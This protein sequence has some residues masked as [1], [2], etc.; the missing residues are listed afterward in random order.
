LRSI[1]EK[2]LRKFALAVG[3]CIAGAALAGAPGAW[4]VPGDDATVIVEYLTVPGNSDLGELVDC[5]SSRRAVGGGV[6]APGSSWVLASGPLD[7]Q[8]APSEIEDGD[9]PRYWYVAVHNAGASQHTYPVYATCSASSDATVQ[10]QQFDVA[11]GTG[12]MPARDG[13]AAECPSE[14]RTIGGGLV[15]VTTPLS[16]ATSADASGPLDESGLTRNTEDGDVAM[17]WYSA[18][19]NVTSGS[20]YYRTVAI[21][22]PASTATVQVTPADANLYSLTAA[23]P[24]CPTGSRALSGGVSGEYTIATQIDSSAPAD[25]TGATT[26]GDG[27]VARS[28]SSDVVSLGPDNPE[29]V[30][31][32]VICQPEP[33]ASSVAPATGLRAAALKKCKKKHS[34]KARRKCRRKARRLPA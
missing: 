20:R 19:A 21:C 12:D 28:W 33:P 18:V 15:P 9:V 34:K 10:V 29:P 31:F 3:I 13:A 6:V 11:A 8:A 16:G 7:A 2:T 30:R 1:R 25:A 4:A 27:E 24:G 14:E 26:L 22:S 23:A 17:F 32:S 5:G